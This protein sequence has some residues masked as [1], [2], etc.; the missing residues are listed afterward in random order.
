MTAFTLKL[1]ALI[2][3]AIDHIGYVFGRG[4]WKIIPFNSAYLRYIGRISFPLFAFSIVNGWK[5]TKNRSKYFTNLCL[6]AIISQIPFTL[7]FFST[8][9][10]VILPD[11]IPFEF[12]FSVKFFLVAAVCTLTYWY[13]GCQKKINK[14]LLV[15]FVA[16]VLPTISLKI[17]HVWI[18]AGS[19]NVLYTFAT[20]LTLLFAYEKIMEKKYRLWELAWILGGIC[21]VLIT[22][23]RMADYGKYFG[24]IILIF[25]LYALRNNKLWQ[26]VAVFCWCM[27][28]YGF[29]DGNWY[30]ASA[31]ALSTLFVLAY[32]N[33]KGVDN[34]WAKWL[35]YIFYPLHLF[36]LGIVNVCFKFI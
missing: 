32:N 3:M 18:I 36:I 35:F 31:A 28:R 25:V 21:I 14:S 30:T 15:V 17:G 20:T 7:A 6:F 9:K 5:Y 8:N 16:T 29:L 1:I 12:H 13:F 19:L 2:T 27:A 34:K 4:A 26:G 33:K 24:G 23:G 11:S 22:Y 10:S